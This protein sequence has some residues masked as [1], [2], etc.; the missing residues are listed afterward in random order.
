[1]QFYQPTVRPSTLAQAPI[2]IPPS[3]SCDLFSA[4]PR[5]PSPWGNLHPACHIQALTGLQ[6]TQHCQALLLGLHY[7]ASGLSGS[8]AETGIHH[9][10]SP[11]VPSMARTVPTGG[12]RE[13]QVS[14]CISVLPCNLGWQAVTRLER[15]EHWAGRTVRTAL[16][17]REDWSSSSFPG[18]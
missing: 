8:S 13:W 11:V 1:M 12:C 16:G 18:L 14:L 7:S 4:P 2:R 9:S 10:S 15:W 3:P 6:P 17:R 5:P